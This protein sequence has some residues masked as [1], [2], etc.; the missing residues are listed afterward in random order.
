MN[1]TLRGLYL[2]VSLIGST[3]C[4]TAPP[5]FGS[6]PA[7]VEAGA[8]SAPADATLAAS[9]SIVTGP[10]TKLSS[11]SAVGE[12]AD[13]PS[14][15]WGRDSSI[16][17]SP[18]A[19]ATEPAVPCGNG[20]I[21]VGERC[22]DGDREVGDGCNATC[23][24]EEGWDCGLSEPTQCEPKCGDGLL[25]GEEVEAGGCDDEGTDSGDGC[26]SKCN[27]EVGFACSGAPSRC[28]GTC[29]DGVLVDGEECDDANTDTTDGCVSCAIATGFDCENASVESPTA[30]TDVNECEDS[31]ACGAHEV[32]MNTAGSYSCTCGPGYAGASG[33]CEQASCAGLEARC[34][35]LLDSCCQSLPV[36]GGEFGL[37]DPTQSAATI[38][39]YTLDKYE[40][41]VGRFRKFVEAYSGPPA[42][43]AGEHPFI[44]GSGWQ[45]E[46]DGDI[47]ANAAGL[48][49][50]VQCDSTRQT[51]STSG[52]ND[53]LPMNCVSWYEAFAFCVWDG[54]RLPTE[55]E[56]EYAAAGGDEERT[57]PWGDAAPTPTLAVYHCT[58]DGS[59]AGECAASDFVG[60]G[61]RPAGSGRYGH[62]DLDGSI[63]EW[64][65]DVPGPYPGACDNCARTTGEA[66]A[67]RETRGGYWWVDGNGLGA[68]LRNDQQP[69]LHWIDYGFRCARDL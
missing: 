54:G 45:S 49:N 30:C 64:V 51:W 41:T 69:G 65:L 25:V 53:P 27:V 17:D 6:A 26:S 23:R 66:D 20:I 38:A 5:T 24:F 47:A 36:T 35:T 37:G 7:P 56:W 61:S 34:G 40:V 63:R 55:A 50:A 31:A 11:D 32:C 68:A 42:A 29:G 8:A 52:D 9:G 59:D 43:G 1:R 39:T 18:D 33:A 58:G 15:T 12:D 14:E 46:W 60:V 10:S 67:N 21:D 28:A 19:D 62:L 3:S 16:P 44:V 48:M 22:D 57:Y 2:G 13:V 4:S